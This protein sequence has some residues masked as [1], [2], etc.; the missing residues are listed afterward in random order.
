MHAEARHWLDKLH[1]IYQGR[2][3]IVASDVL[4]AA[5]GR[6]GHLLSL[7]AAGVFVVAGTRGVG[8]AVDS[9]LVDIEVLNVEAEGM[10]ARVRASLE[11]FES[12]PATVRDKIDAWDPDGEACVL[13][14]IFATG[15]QVAGRRY[16]GGRPKSWWELEDKT[17]CDAI[18]A[19]AGVLSAPY[20]IVPASQ[21]ALTQAAAR[22]DVGEGTVWAGDSR[23]GFTG[24]GDKVFWV[25]TPEQ[26]SKA[27]AQ[28]GATC[29]RVRVMPFLEGIPCS[30]HG[31]VLPDRVLALR[32]CEMLVVRG[33]EPG[34][35]TYIGTGSTWEP[36]AEDVAAMRAIARAVGEVLA[37]RRDFRGMFTVD[38]VM[39]VDGFRPTEINPRVGGAAG[40]LVGQIE[41]FPFELVQYAL[42]EGSE[43]DWEGDRLERA[44]LAASEDSRLARGPV[45]VDTRLPAGRLFWRRE[46]DG[47][48]VVDRE[49]LATAVVSVGNLM[50]G[51]MLIFRI[52]PKALPTGPSAA[53][54]V[55]GLLQAVGRHFDVALPKWDLAQE[56]R[57]W[58]SP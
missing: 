2:K 29:E 27:A 28:L 23:D 25:Q 53:G 40:M 44:I 41:G 39:T 10:V 50:Q 33:P 58:G 45:V 6:V 3:W 17:R 52:L 43:V 7:D 26:A 51:S 36:P 46:A 24:G 48:Q 9:T 30:I 11:A 1:P 22:L 38:G 57:A 14:P 32:P 37:R 16:F 8:E 47:W 34:H 20:E 35:F 54:E 19:E 5:N 21:A 18:L 4:V 56:R 12:V 13:G 31:L 42:A 49:T 55:M 15:T